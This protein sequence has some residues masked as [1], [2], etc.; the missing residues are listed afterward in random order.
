MG[1]PQ[2]PDGEP[3]PEPETD[4]PRLR[5][6]LLLPSVRPQDPAG[7]DD[8]GPR[9]YRQGR[10]GAVRGHLQLPAGG[11]GLC[12]SI[13]ERPGCS[14]PDL[15]GPVQ[16]PEP[17]AGAGD[18]GPGQGERRGLHRLLAAGTGAPDRPLPG[19]HP[20]RFPDGEGEVPQVL[21][22][23]ARDAGG[24]CQTERQRSPRWPSPGASRTTG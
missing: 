9:G 23:D 8:A 21:G 20:G 19:R 11:R 1:L 10:Q 17:G 13:P 12:L 16:H 7:G 4:E 14:L 2:I 5:G 24:A 22:P 3:G 15:P 18:P 6:P